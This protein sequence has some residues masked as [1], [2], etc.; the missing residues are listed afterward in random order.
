MEEWKDTEYPNYQV[1][2]Y[3]NIR[4]RGFANRKIVLDSKGYH[5]VQLSLGSS[6]N[7]KSVSVHRLVA[8]A[9]IPNPENLPFV[10]HIDNNKSNNHVTNL[11][12]CTG[13][14]NAANASA[15]NA[16]NLKGVWKHGKKYQS[17]IRCNGVRFFLGTFPTPEEAHEAYKAKAVELFG[18]FARW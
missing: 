6:R 3:G 14:Q 16:L 1:S 15:Y 5:R 2:N 12:W 4:L 8:Q 7:Y 13:S 11:R 10:D 18:E 9:F 17:E